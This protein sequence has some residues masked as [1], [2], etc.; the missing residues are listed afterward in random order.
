MNKSHYIVVCFLCALIPLFSDKCYKKTFE[1]LDRKAC[2][3]YQRVLPSTKHNKNVVMINVDDASVEKIGNWPFSRDVYAKMLENLK[4]E[5]IHSLI[6][7]LSFLDKS[8]AKVDENYVT[9]ILPSYIQSYLDNAVALIGDVVS[10]DPKKA[11]SQFEEIL[12]QAKNNILIS[13]S[14]VIRPLD[15]I[16]SDSIKKN[17]NAF[18]NFTMTEGAGGVPVDFSTEYVSLKKVTAIKD[19]KTPEYPSITPSLSMFVNNAVGSGFVNADPDRDGYIRRVH[20]VA[21]YNGEYYGQ[22]VFVPILRYYGNPSVVVTNNKIVL[23]DAKFPDGSVKDITIPRD[24]D[25][26]VI[27]KFSKE[28]YVKYNSISLWNI[29]R[30]SLLEEQMNDMLYQMEDAGLFS[31]LSDL[32]PIETMSAMKYIREELSNGEDASN[33]ITYSSYLEILANIL[34]R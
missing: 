17:G 13:T 12:E 26:S 14:Y 30:L 5:E 7:D 15:G 31:L 21:K 8:P 20:L 10:K 2:D 23:K 28:K 9:N 33:G 6:F 29:Y 18:L 24:K 19:D 22:L 3:I 16:F 32:S 4:D 27:L 11:Q 1:T 34:N 25:G